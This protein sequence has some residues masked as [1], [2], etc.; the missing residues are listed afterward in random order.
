MTNNLLAVFFGGGLGC[1]ARFAV[2]MLAMRVA[3]PGF[4][5]GTLAVNLIGAFCIGLFIEYMAMKNNAHPILP[6]LLVTGFLGGFT[7]FSAFSLESA[8][9]WIRGTY[10]PLII[11]VAVSVIGTLACVLLAMRLARA[12]F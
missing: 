3:S 7:T 4:P 9:M 6:Y 1:V 12:W 8:Q 10:A 2:S 11:Y 5:W